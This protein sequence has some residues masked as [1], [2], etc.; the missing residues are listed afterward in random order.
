MLCTLAVAFFSLDIWNCARDTVPLG[1]SDSEADMKTTKSSCEGSRV[2]HKAKP[3]SVTVPSKR[4][5]QV[6]VWRGILLWLGRK[7]TGYL[8]I[9]KNIISH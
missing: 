8:E 4:Q 3:S 1:T 2:G 6:T 9:F 7:Q 5:K